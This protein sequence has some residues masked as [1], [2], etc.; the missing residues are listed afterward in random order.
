MRF[1]HRT[2]TTRV[3]ASPRRAPFARVAAAAL[4]LLVALG[5]LAP[6]ACSA[7]A[8]ESRYCVRVSDGDTIVLDRGERV[9]LIG[10][11]TPELHHPVKP[12]EHFA[13]EARD[14]VRRLVAGKRI[15]LEYD[16][17]RRDQYGRTLAYVYLADGTLLNLRIIEAGFGFAYTKHPFRADLMRRFRQA[18]RRARDTDQ[19]LWATR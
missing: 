18:E 10:V 19:G 12:V 4:A 2:M 6:L 8:R 15:W 9:R 13:R 14:H 16:R 5:G 3:P 1:R 17:V 7:P 11:D